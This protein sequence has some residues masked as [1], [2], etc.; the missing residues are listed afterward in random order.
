MMATSAKDRHE[1]A[2]WLER[3]SRL[4][5]LLRPP[6][7]HFVFDGET[8]SLFFSGR[9]VSPGHGIDPAFR[10]SIQLLIGRFFFLEVFFKDVGEI[11][12]AHLP[13]PGDQRPVARHL[14]VLDSLCGSDDCSIEDVLLAD[15]AGEVVALTR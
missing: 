3:A 12:A 11:I 13:R 15:V 7:V 14:V 10:Y 6:C 2:H 5:R 9:L 4:G 8:R 1:Y